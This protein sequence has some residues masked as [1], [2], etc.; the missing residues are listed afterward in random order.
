MIRLYYSH[1]RILSIAEGAICLEVGFSSPAWL[2]M[3]SWD[4][5]EMVSRCL[6]QV[7]SLGSVNLSH[8]FTHYPPKIQVLF[9]RRERWFFDSHGVILTLIHWLGLQFLPQ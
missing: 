7:P 4:I 2:I 9:R 6:P 3:L 1:K 8:L 5:T